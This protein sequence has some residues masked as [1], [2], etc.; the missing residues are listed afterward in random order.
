[1]KKYEQFL[2]FLIT[3]S[4]S[5]NQ[6]LKKF[7][8]E[9]SAQVDN[10]KFSEAKLTIEKLSKELD[11]EI[12]KNTILRYKGLIEMMQVRFSTEIPQLSALTPEELLQELNRQIP[13]EFE[14]D[15]F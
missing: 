15:E 6:I 8:L 12:D 11:T 1:M 7:V 10:V 9:L 4:L 13:P 3:Q 14:E 2:L 5:Q